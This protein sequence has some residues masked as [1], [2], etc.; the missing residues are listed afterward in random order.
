[1][2]RTEVGPKYAGSRSAVWRLALASAALAV[3]LGWTAA[4]EAQEITWRYPPLPGGVNPL[5]DYLVTGQGFHMDNYARWKY[6]PTADAYIVA[7]NPGGWRIKYKT[8]SGVRVAAVDFLDVAYYH[9]RGEFGQMRLRNWGVYLRGNRAS[10]W[11]G[12][13]VVR[14]R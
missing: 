2:R 4:A 8:R 11:K 9:G 6:G 1:M 10:S 3:G 7:N 14:I 12:A 13:Y 5:Y